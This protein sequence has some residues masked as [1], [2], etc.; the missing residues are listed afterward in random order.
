M[1][2]RAHSVHANWRV[3]STVSELCRRLMAVEAK[4]GA[5]DRPNLWSGKCKSNEK[6]EGSCLQGERSSAISEAI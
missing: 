1:V 2:D 3:G 6:G 4:A 5:R